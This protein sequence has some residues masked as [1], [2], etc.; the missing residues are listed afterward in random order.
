MEILDVSAIVNLAIQGGERVVDLVK[1]LVT[2]E[3]AFYE[4]GN[5]V[6]KLC[7][8]KHKMTREQA[9]T[10][11][12]TVSN[13]LAMMKTPSYD[14]LLPGEILQLAFDEKRTYYDT[15]YTQAGKAKGL[16]LVTNDRHLAAAAAHHIR[17]KSSHELQPDLN[18]RG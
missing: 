10:L 5:G 8:L 14:E 11:I 12:E 7:S 18:W 4:S 16:S 2:L 13:L 6:W 9:T 15:T 17:T 3:L 1:G